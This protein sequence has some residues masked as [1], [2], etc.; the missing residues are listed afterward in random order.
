MSAPP[1]SPKKS[2]LSVATILLAAGSSSRLG[3]PKQLLPFGETT[4]LR[5]AAKTALAAALGPV[6]VVLGAVEKQCRETLSG[7]PVTIVS[8]SNWE[9]GMGSSIA[10]GMRAVGKI[11]HRAVI[12][13]LCDQPAITARLL[14]SLAE[15]QRSVGKSIVASHHG[16]NL[17]P[18]ALFT[19]DHFPQL[20]LLRGRHG[21]R[22]LFQNQPDLSSLACPEAAL[23][24]DTEND[25]AFLSLASGED[26]A[27]QSGDCAHSALGTVIRGD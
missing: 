5:Y 20:R 7:L 27:R 17:G 8:N 26:K 21:A 11:L 4:L 6:I 13:M 9:E 24:I 22:S 19:A 15:H 10:T 3:Q 2:V 14:R 18:P 25:L 1:T 12:I 23:D 16:D